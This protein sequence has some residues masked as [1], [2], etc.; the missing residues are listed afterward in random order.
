MPSCG[1]TV[2]LPRC[3]AQ[4]PSHYNLCFRSRRARFVR[5][6]GLSPAHRTVRHRATTR[7]LRGAARRNIGL[8]TRRTPLRKLGWREPSFA[9][10]R[11]P[12]TPARS[13]STSL[14]P[15]F[16]FSLVFTFCRCSVRD[17]LLHQDLRD[18]TLQVCH[19]TEWEK[20]CPVEDRSAQ[21]GNHRQSGRCYTTKLVARTRRSYCTSIVASAA[22]RRLEEITV[23]KRVS[24][25]V[26][27]R[28]FRREGPTWRELLVHIQVSVRRPDHLPPIYLCLH[29]PACAIAYTAQE[30]K[31]PPPLRACYLPWSFLLKLD[32]HILLRGISSCLRIER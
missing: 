5:I 14:S 3:T 18:L 21:L 20:F 27:N 24:L 30:V 31:V 32:R 4:V 11:I 28:V 29:C 6:S 13:L 15:L 16:L 26:I 25:A 1:S 7:L 9:P 17:T 10:L 2:K 22:N 8:T 23:S 12:R 19:D